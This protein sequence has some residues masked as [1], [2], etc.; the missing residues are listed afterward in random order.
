MPL[1]EYNQL[2]ILIFLPGFDGTGMSAMHQF[3]SLM[4]SF[5]V[6][7]CTIPLDDRTPFAEL[8]NAVE[9]FIG[10]YIEQ[11]G[12]DRPVYLLAESFGAL[13]AL[14]AAAQCP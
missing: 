3:P 13:L 10:Q 11:Q 6:V 14:M 8:V 2:P 4:E 7:T 12:Q 9:E 1:K 5:D